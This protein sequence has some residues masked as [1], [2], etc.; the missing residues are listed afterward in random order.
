MDTELSPTTD[1]QPRR[2]ADAPSEPRFQTLIEGLDAVVWEM[3]VA[4]R[5]FTYVSPQAE[6]LLGYPVDRWYGDPDFWPDTLVHPEDQA[7]VVERWAHSLR[8]GESYEMHFRL[9][10]AGGEFRWHLGRASV[11]RDAAGGVVRWFGSNTDIHDQKESEAERE[12]LIA[13]LETERNRLENIFANAPA[14]IAVSRGPR[15][16]RGRLPPLHGGRQRAW[17]CPGVPRAYLW[18]LPDLGGARQGGGNG[19]RP[20]PGEKDR[21]EPGWASLDRVPGGGGGLLPLHLAER[22]GRVVNDANTTKGEDAGRDLPGL[23]TEPGRR[24]V[25]PHLKRGAPFAT[26]LQVDSRP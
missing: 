20:V 18:H 11:Q 2:D 14:G 13:A 8:V 9:R 12:R 4:T 21:G 15:G 24:V 19:H 7:G 6:R 5:I 3:D 23:H 10:S 1:A 17:H 16:G 25:I 26:F 22:G